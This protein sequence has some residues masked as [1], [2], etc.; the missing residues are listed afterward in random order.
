MN[1]ARTIKRNI[2]RN[3]VGKNRNVRQSWRNRMTEKLGV[4]DY[5]INYNR[6][7]GRKV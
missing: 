3:E 2:V 7:S 5:I 1:F 4:L 6:T